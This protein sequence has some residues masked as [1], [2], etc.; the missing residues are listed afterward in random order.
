MSAIPGAE[1]RSSDPLAVVS[2]VLS[3]VA[4][5]LAIVSGP[6]SLA[7]QL[8]LGAPASWIGLVV[9]LPV[10]VVGVAAL[11]VGLVGLSRQGSRRAMAGAGA[12]LGGFLTIGQM[13]GLLTLLVLNLAR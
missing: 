6:I 11:V 9:G 1:R 8:R 2:L 10:L 3:I 4:A 5:L 12:G 7:V 13:V